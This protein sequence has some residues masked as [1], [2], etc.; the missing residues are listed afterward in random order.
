MKTSEK[1]LKLA[2]APAQILPRY[3]RNLCK[4]KKPGCLKPG[5]FKVAES[6]AQPCWAGILPLGSLRGNPRPR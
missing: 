4:L 5:F 1:I 3:C 2:R 6:E